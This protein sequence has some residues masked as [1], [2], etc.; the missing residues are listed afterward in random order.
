MTPSPATLSPDAEHDADLDIYV[1]SVLGRKARNPVLLDVRPLTTLADAFL[2]CH[3]TSTRQVSAIAEHIQRTLKK[4]GIKA[5]GVEGLQEG[6]W[7][8]M[9]YGHVLI[10]VFYETARLFYD[11]EGL[12]ADARRIRTPSMAA[13]IEESASAPDDAEESFFID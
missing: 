12:W 2:I 13:L 9:D 5:L 8:L 1:K 6:H 7:V 10:H 11:L 3:G 4:Q